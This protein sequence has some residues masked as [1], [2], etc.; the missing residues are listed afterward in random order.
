MDWKNKFTEILKGWNSSFLSNPPVQKTWF[1]LS[2]VLPFSSFEF[3]TWFSKAN[4]AEVLWVLLSSGRDPLKAP[5]RIS[6][7][8]CGW[9]EVICPTVF[10]ESNSHGVQEGSFV[11]SFSTTQ[12]AF[13]SF[14]FHFLPF[15]SLIQFSY[16][17]QKSTSVELLKELAEIPSRNSCTWTEWFSPC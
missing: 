16:S 14:F 4:K 12:R 3:V 1:T 10:P 7:Y 5:P 2:E 13:C 15:C 6:T 11:G 8:Q 17:F 9:K